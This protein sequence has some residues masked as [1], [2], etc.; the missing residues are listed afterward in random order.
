MRG[1]RFLFIRSWYFPITEFAENQQMLLEGRVDSKK[2][3]SHT[4]PLEGLS[5]AYD[6]F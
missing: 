2:L 3:I 1:A 4:F 6:L 5:A